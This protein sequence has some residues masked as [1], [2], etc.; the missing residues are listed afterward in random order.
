MI[1][2][3]RI[4]VA[5]LRGLFGGRRAERELDDEIETHL[6]LLTERYVC[7]GMDEAE[8][9]QAARRQFA[10]GSASRDAWNQTPRDA[11]S[12]CSIWPSHLSQE[13]GVYRRRSLN[14]RLRHRR[15]PDDFQFR[16]YVFPEAHPRARAEAVSKIRRPPGWGLCLSEIRAVPRP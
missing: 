14:A 3:L 7:Q 11:L 15:E 12:G 8:A 5:K 10:A 6:R 9:A 4:L 1:H 13:S 2:Y 16:G